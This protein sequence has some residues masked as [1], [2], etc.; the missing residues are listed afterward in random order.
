[1]TPGIEDT[2][3]SAQDT[4]PSEDPIDLDRAARA[5]LQWQREMPELS[6]KLDP[7]VLLGRLAEA[8]Q[9]V[10][11][12][13]IAPALAHAGLKAGDFDVLATLVR[14]GPPYELTPTVLYRSTM[15]SSGGMTARLDKLEKTG[16][17]ERRSH[18]EDRRA[19]I[20]CL[21]EKGKTVIT[22]IMPDYVAR[23]EAALRGLSPE[24]QQ[25]LSDLLGQLLAS[26]SEPEM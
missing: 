17:I 3:V 15:I 14:S 11:N 10:A 9:L 18:S 23:Q 5:K 6:E 24:D 22:A 25:N 21:T 16:L 26:L 12:Q 8:Q 7:M 13:V 4:P 20:V 1:M 2:E 19:L